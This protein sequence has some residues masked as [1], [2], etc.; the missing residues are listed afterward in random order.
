VKVT[1][2]TN[3]LVRAIT[4][5]GERQGKTAQAA[6][7]RAEM[8]A[9][10]LPAFCELV[11]VLAQGYK[12][13][14]VDIAQAIRRLVNAANVVANRPAVEAGLAVLDAGGDFADGIIAHE[15][16][17]LGAETFVSFDKQA[18]K[19]MAALGGSARLLS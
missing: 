3:V 6:L 9:L 12:V 4:G 1:A 7:A 5:D 2:D 19:M 13:P 17:W 14:S 18:V 11:W 8:I 16:N 15:G 10:T